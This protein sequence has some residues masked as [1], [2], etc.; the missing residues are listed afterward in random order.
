[1]KWLQKLEDEEM[2]EIVPSRNDRETLSTIL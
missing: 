2:N 1:M